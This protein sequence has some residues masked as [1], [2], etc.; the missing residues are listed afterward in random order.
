ML[1]LIPQQFPS[2]VYFAYIGDLVMCIYKTEAQIHKLTTLVS[3]AVTLQQ[4]V[5]LVHILGINSMYSSVK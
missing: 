3:F 2:I 5:A 1:F 4:P